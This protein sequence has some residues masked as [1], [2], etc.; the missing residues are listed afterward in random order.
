VINDDGI[1]KEMNDLP[2]RKLVEVLGPCSAESAFKLS[3]SQ[4]LPGEIK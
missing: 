2:L 3:L 1:A 4:K